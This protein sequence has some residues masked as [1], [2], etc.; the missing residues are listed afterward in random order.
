MDDPVHREGVRV[1]KLNRI[2]NDSLN[3]LKNYQFNG[4]RVLFPHFNSVKN[5]GYTTQENLYDR[6]DITDRK[7]EVTQRD[8]L[9]Q[10]METGEFIP[11]PMEVQWS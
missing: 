10:Y 3:R 8:L 1:P 4:L 6:R 7:Y 2:W 5:V 9:L 11:G